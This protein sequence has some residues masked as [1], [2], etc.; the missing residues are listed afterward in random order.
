MN[1]SDIIAMLA[2]LA[3]LLA[4]RDSRRVA[5]LSK[6]QY[7]A[8]KREESLNLAMELKTA[9]EIAILD[10]DIALEYSNLSL[11]TDIILRIGRVRDS[12]KGISESIIRTIEKLRDDSILEI[13]DPAHWLSCIREIS[14]AKSDFVNLNKEIAELKEDI[15][16]RRK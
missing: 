2:L 15:G 13:S 3:S 11:P 4:L 16:K 10:L 5:S 9:S 8:E 1:T 14:A 6:R 7:A 12:I